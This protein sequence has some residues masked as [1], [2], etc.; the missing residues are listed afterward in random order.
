MLLSLTAPALSSLPSAPAKLYLDFVG[1]Q[2]RRWGSWAGI[3]GYLVPQI[4]AFDTDGDPSSFSSKELD[5]IQQIWAIVAE[6]YSPF[7]LNVTTIDPGKLDDK[8][9]C[10]VVI[11]GDGKWYGKAGGVAFVATFSGGNVL[12]NNKIGYVWRG[13]GNGGDVVSIANGVAHEAGHMFG[14]H[15]RTLYPISQPPVEYAP[16][17]IMGEGNGGLGVWTVGERSDKSGDTLSY[18]GVQDDVAVLAGSDNAF[19]F[20]PDETGATA[21]TAVNMNVVGD[22]RVASGVI[23]RPSDVDAWRFTTLGGPLKLDVNVPSLGAMLYANLE[24][25]DANFS[26]LDSAQAPAQSQTLFYDLPPGTYYAVVKSRG[27]YSDIGSYS[28]LAQI[29]EQFDNSISTATHFGQFGGIFLIQDT[30]FEGHAHF[31]GF[32]GNGDP[33]DYYTFITGPVGGYFSANLSGLSGDADLELIRDYD[34]DG[35]LDPGEVIQQSENPGPSNESVGPIL[36]TANT[37]YYIHVHRY[38]SDSTNYALDAYMNEAGTPRDVLL[39]RALGDGGGKNTWYDYVGTNTPEDF[40][41]I[42]VNNVGRLNLTLNRLTDDA[43]LYLY[44]DDKGDG[45]PTID[46]LVASSTQVGATPEQISDVLVT[47]GTYFIQV[48]SYNG[49]DTNFALTTNLD[50]APFDNGTDVLLPSTPL[51]NVGLMTGTAEVHNYVGATD[52]LD[53]FKMTVPPGW[54]R[55]R[56]TRG[57]ALHTMQLIY[58]AD[59]DGVVESGDILATGTGSIEYNVPDLSGSGLSLLFLRIAPTGGDIPSDGNYTLD[60]YGR[61]VAVANTNS[62]GSESIDP[63]TPNGTTVSGQIYWSASAPVNH[64]EAWYSFVMPQSGQFTALLTGSAGP[65]L[66]V[67]ESVNNNGQIEPGQRLAGAPAESQSGDSQIGVNLPA[68]SYFLRV[69]IP[70]DTRDDRTYSFPYTLTVRTTAV[71]D[72]TPPVVDSA[73]FEFGTLPQGIRIQFSKDVGDSLAEGV[74]IIQPL[75]PGALPFLPAE[76]VYDPETRTLGL[77]FGGVLPDGNYRLQIPA[78][79]IHDSAGNALAADFTYD[80]F[81]LTG[82]VNHD[83]KVDFTDFVTLARNYGK[84]GAAYADGDLDYDGKVDFNDLIILARHYGQSVPTAAALTSTVADDRLTLPLRRRRR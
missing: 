23:T 46:E 48:R 66:Q 25:R 44:R 26:L 21:N 72:T 24:L 29:N 54:L 13:Q 55:I 77:S 27:Y 70:T 51:P 45:N 32:V 7:N 20:R 50:Y 82:D 64:S 31:N 3:G 2:Q 60:V 15:H 52:P 37:R 11:G 79:A 28:L 39:P 43:D 12:D 9:A 59:G 42:D 30:P 22:Q 40:Y 36:L 19:G 76:Q 41:R 6:K 33:E 18:K 5:Q 34:N 78:G 38:G 74:A 8:K 80:F 56:Q 16:G 83:G 53:V 75:A 68:G 63:N 65:Q 10:E 62:A 57:G 69:L 1:D 49:A 58:D 71:T 84:G 81:M 73:S 14:L 17:Y 35:I 47:P 4:P 61:D 67:F